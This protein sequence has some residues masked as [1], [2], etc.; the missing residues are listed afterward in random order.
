MQSFVVTSLAK[1][2]LN[3]LG[4]EK[5]LQTQIA[6]I[7][8]L[9]INT[10][11]QTSFLLDVRLTNQEKLCLLLAAFGKTA[12]STAKLLGISIET[13]KEYRKE[14]RRKLGC[15]TIAHAVYQ[16]IRYGFLNNLSDKPPLYRG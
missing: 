8:S 2:V 15:S 5:P 1:R 12:Q 14:I 4:I 6:N 3:E 9:L 10:T 13:V 7:E 16:G 11:I